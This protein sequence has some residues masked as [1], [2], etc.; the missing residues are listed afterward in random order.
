[1]ISVFA[2][3]TAKAGKRLEVLELARANLANVRAESGCHEYRLVTDVENAS[4]LQT[5]LG[6]DSFAFIEK[7]ES[8]PALGAHLETP[9]MKAYFEKTADLMADQ[10]IH[11]MESAD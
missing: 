5:P 1:M 11:V 7:W 9:H 4:P 8:L 2:I 3:M 6:Q 10:V